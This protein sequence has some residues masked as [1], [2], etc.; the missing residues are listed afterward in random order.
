MKPSKITEQSR[1]KKNAI[2]LLFVFLVVILIIS[3]TVLFIVQLPI[4][5]FKYLKSEY[6]DF[7]CKAPQWVRQG[8][9][10]YCQH[11]LK[12]NIEWLKNLNIAEVL[13]LDIDKMAAFADQN[14]VEGVDKVHIMGDLPG[15][16]D[17]KNTAININA[18]GIGNLAFVALNHSDAK[19]GQKA[20]ETINYLKNFYGIK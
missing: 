4:T 14:C 8:I 17:Y 6:Q 10:V 20:F 18:T 9:N 5:F 3:D 12:H 15:P 2:K 19:T 7:I 1:R 11:G 16:A 13:A